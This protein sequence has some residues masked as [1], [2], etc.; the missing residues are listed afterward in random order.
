MRSVYFET[1]KEALEAIKDVRMGYVLFAAPH[2]VNELSVRVGDHVVLCSTAGEFTDKGYRNGVITGFEFPRDCAEFVPI[3]S[4]PALSK[5]RLQ[6]G[7]ARVRNNNNAFMLLLCDG[8]SGMEEKI[9]TTLFF[10]DEKF[11]VIGGSA[12]DALTFTETPIFVGTQRVHS[13]GIFFN[14]QRRT[15]ILKENI[16]IPS[17]KELLVTE[18]DPMNRIVKSFNNKP[19]SVEYARILGVKEPDLANH[20]ANHPL[21]IAYGKETYIASPQKVN[22]DK[23]ITFYCQIMPNTFVQILESVEVVSKINETL[24]MIPFKP[25][26]VLAVN[27]ILRSLKFQQDGLWPKIDSAMLGFCPNTTG[28]ISYGEQYYQRHVNQTMVLLAEE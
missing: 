13:V 10:M 28:F 8:L 2:K 26:F 4:P 21:G 1:V 17:N 24:K 9:I 25:G 5:N 15:H 27:C 18:A 22:A 19:A 20:F 6:E 7:Y 16:Y 3:E 14:S 23:S 11:K 12:G